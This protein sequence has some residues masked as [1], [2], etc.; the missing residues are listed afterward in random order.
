MRTCTNCGKKM[1]SGYC[2]H[3]GWEYYCSDECLHKEYTEQDYLDMYNA[4]EA[5]WTEWEEEDEECEI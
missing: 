3:D 4:G 5:Y 2:I 1:D